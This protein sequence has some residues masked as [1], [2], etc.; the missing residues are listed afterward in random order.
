MKKQNWKSI[1]CMIAA[2]VCI[3]IIA[4]FI[5]IHYGKPLA[6]L[7]QD[8]HVFR[9]WIAQYGALSA[10]IMILCA[11]FKV[12]FPMLPGKL[13]EIA[14]GFCFGFWKGFLLIQIANAL[15]TMVVWGLVHVFGT[16]IV[17]LFLNEEQVQTFRL[18][19]DEQHFSTMVGITYLIPGTPKDAFTYALCLSPMPLWKMTAITTIARSFTVVA[20][21]MSGDAL[22]QA[23][24]MTA[25]FVLA[26]FMGTSSLCLWIYHH[27]RKKKGE[28]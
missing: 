6:Q 12:I 28:E 19:K 9:D 20:G 10:C 27:Y 4:L 22:G 1:L 2:M 26:G 18:W 3:L 23:N 13:L 11:M 5:F 16:R 14:A 17:Y 7:A 21:V 15:G 24:L 8:P 25:I